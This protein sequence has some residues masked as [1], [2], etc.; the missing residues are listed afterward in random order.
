MS[1]HKTLLIPVTGSIS[2]PIAIT[3]VMGLI[4]SGTATPVEAGSSDWAKYF[5]PI[6]QKS[7][8]NKSQD[9]EIKKK[10]FKTDKAI[11]NKPIPN[12]VLR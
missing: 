9:R 8:V 12:R 1:K 5:N 4:I 2:A 7:Y 11:D 6:P 3:A 10:A